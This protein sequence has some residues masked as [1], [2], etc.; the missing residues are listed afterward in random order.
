MDYVT[1]D[2]GQRQEFS[3][4]MVRDSGAKEL[5]PDLIWMPM[6][7]AYLSSP[8]TGE[9]DVEERKK[10]ALDAFLDWYSQTNDA[11]GTGAT[12]LAAID[13]VESFAD[14]GKLVPR[15]AAL[16]GRGA[17]KYGENNWKKARTQEE[18]DRFKAS[19]F[20]HFVQWIYGLNTEEDH[21]AAVAFN[22]SGAEYVKERMAADDSVVKE[23]T[24]PEVVPTVWDP[25]PGDRVRIV[26]SC[27]FTPSGWREGTIDEIVYG[28]KHHPF[29][30]RF[31][32][33]SLL[34]YKRD[35]F[36]RIESGAV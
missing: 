25:K 24:K 7:E 12:V 11:K 14:R 1:N 21:A 9:D 30:I 26:D 15:W 16:M 33:G 22:I 29:L 10:D 2:S 13:D 27:G 17:I 32:G 18:L 35:E 19:A 36:E 4:G 28:K 3:T 31:N 5:R 6:L 8:P 23:L 20:R 34:A